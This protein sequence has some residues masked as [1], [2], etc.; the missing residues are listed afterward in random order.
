MYPPADCTSWSMRLPGRVVVPLNS[1]CSKTCDRPAPSHLPSVMLPAWH[2]ACAETTGALWSSRVM[3]TNP[4]SS[5]VRLAPGG[6]G[7]ISAATGLWLRFRRAS[8]FAGPFLIRT[9]QDKESR[10]G[11]QGIA[12]QKDPCGTVKRGLR[13]PRSTRR[14]TKRLPMR[15]HRTRIGQTRLPCATPLFPSSRARRRSGWGRR[16]RGGARKAHRRRNPPRRARLPIPI[17][18]AGAGA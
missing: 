1:M 12:R 13:A 9:S 7:G 14:T 15:C 4:F 10:G 8:F 17:P 5:V 11:M 2:Q 16:R 18:G 6:M 3:T